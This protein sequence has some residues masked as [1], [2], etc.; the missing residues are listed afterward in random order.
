VTIV[1]ST[2]YMDEAERCSR[3]GFLDHGKLIA[4]GRPEDLRDKF[5]GTILEIVA[6]QR[7]V[8]KDVLAALPHAAGVNLLGRDCT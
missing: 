7:F 6:D 4:V 5:K 2:P 3:V 1:V 8:A